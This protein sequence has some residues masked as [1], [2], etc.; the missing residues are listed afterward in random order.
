MSMSADPQASLARWQRSLLPA[1]LY[2]ASDGRRSARDW[3]VDLWML[4]IA[5]ANGTALL[6]STWD[7]HSGVG[8][9][10]DIALGALA[11]PALWFRRSHPTAVG[12]GTGLLAIVSGA[13]AGPA[14][15]ALFNAAVRAPWRGLAATA[16][17]GVVNSVVFP[18]IYPGKDSYPLT[19]LIG[20]LVTVI[21]VGWGL[22]VRAR[23]ELVYSLRERAAR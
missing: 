2:E 15:L 10:L 23:R 19:V 1:G 12:V 20:L 6:A 16:A 9:V 4:L 7:E 13:A 18:L 3:I 22:F 21:V 17:I 8:Y 11:L 5:F 14:L